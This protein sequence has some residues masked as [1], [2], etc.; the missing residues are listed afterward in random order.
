MYTDVTQ[1]VRS[2]EVCC[3]YTK[4]RKADRAPLQSLPTAQNTFCTY[5]IDIIDKLPKTAKGY[6]YILLVVDSF[7][8]ACE[9]I[10][11]KSI[12]AHKIAIAIFENII[13]RYGTSNSILSDKDS[14]FISAVMEHLCRLTGTK[15]L[16]ATAHNHQTVG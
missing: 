1:Y 12:D 7:I 4:P 11:L 15:H 6:K 13:C 8:K 2:C 3:K 5:V 9:L 16:S 14:Q 10:P